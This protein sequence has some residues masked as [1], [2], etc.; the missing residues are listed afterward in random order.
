MVHSREDFEAAVEASQILFGKGTTDSLR[1][2]SE[3]TFL[4]VFEGV[5]VFDVKKEF[6]LNGIT[7]SDLCAVQTQVFPSK[8][9]VRRAVQGG[10]LSLNKEKIENA[11]MIVNG[12]FLLNGKYLLIQ[13]GKKNYSLLR[14]VG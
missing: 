7:I 8:G 6:I 10:G 12:N 2:M 9:E 14:I 4:S 1:K 11:E 5:P 3:N 13:K